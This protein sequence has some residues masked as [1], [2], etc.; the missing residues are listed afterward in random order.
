MNFLFK[1]LKIPNPKQLGKSYPQ[2]RA[3]LGLN[4]GL[5]TWEQYYKEIK[6]KY[7]IRY[8]FAKTLYSFIRY[9]IWNKVYLIMELLWWFRYNFIPSYKYHFLDLRQPKGFDEYRYGY[10]DMPEKML[11]ANF[12]LLKEYL[13]DSSWDLSSE[14][15][16][17]E[18]LNDKHLLKSYLVE[19][20]AKLLNYWW[21]KIRKD[22]HLNLEKMRL[23]KGYVVEYY[24]AADKFEAKEEEMLIRLMKIRKHLWD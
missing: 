13:K 19:K 5:Y 11:Y 17:E 14:V 8:F 7:P 15:G 24:E 9:K 23:E 6:E 3:S 16:L 2:L 18:V 10:R 21:V 1:L 12:N 22:D 4:K 20:E